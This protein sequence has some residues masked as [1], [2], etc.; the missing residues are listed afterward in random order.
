MNQDDDI[1]DVMNA[2]PCMWDG[3]YYPSRKIAAQKTGINYIT[4]L[5]YLKRGYTGTDDIY[6]IAWN[7]AR[8]KSIHAA[9][10]G[11]QY[12]RSTIEQAISDGLT[13]DS[14]VPEWQADR[15]YTSPVTVNGAYYPSQSEAARAL[16]I[17]RERVRQLVDQHGDNFSYGG[18]KH[19]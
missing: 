9:T 12:S 18:K 16:D 17:S 1:F 15:G 4:F 11:S 5:R 8:Y 6:P 7:G 13:C 19:L 3:E 2:I 10:Q 14:Q